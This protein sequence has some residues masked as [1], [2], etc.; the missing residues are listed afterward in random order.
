MEPL[1]CIGRYVLR[2]DVLEHFIADGVE[3][4][5]ELGTLER[6]RV[7]HFVGGGGGDLR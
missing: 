1:E 2:L 4:V 6:F 7:G 5:G 3:H